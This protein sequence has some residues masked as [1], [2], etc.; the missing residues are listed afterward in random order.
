MSN[1]PATT[2]PIAILT[3]DGLQDAP[4][5]ASSL[6]DAV[7]FEPQGVYSV[8]RTFKRVYTLMLDDHFDR[9]EES[10]R[11]IEMPLSLDRP[12]VRRALR[13][14][15]DRAGFAET[16]FRIT[17]PRQAPHTVMLSLE[18]FVGIP[19][20]VIQQGVRVMTAP[21]V[22]ENPHAKVT[23]WMQ[24]R[25]STLGQ[26][27]E[28]VYETLLVAPSGEILEGASSNFWAVMDGTLHTAEEG[29]LNGIV[30]RALLH[31]APQ[32][33]PIK[34]HP[35]RK[36][37]L[38]LVEEAFLTSASR[39]VVPIVIIDSQIIADGKPGPNTMWLREAYDEWAAAHL[40]EL[41]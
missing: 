4:Y 18:P 20:E 22:R 32:M 35:I 23:S 11:L 14:L 29:V 10:A 30:R 27:P 28:G 8:A 16:R 12:A 7:K 17:V 13:T 25:V 41:I 6:A 37:E 36:D 2:I 34:L 33:L 1:Q 40:E 31:I 15:I 39:G 5:S 3:P 38:W 24:Q 21:L 9:M 19:P 26:I